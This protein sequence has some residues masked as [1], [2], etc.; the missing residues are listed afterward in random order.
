[1]VTHR[2]AN[3]RQQSSDSAGEALRGALRSEHAE[4]YENLLAVPLQQGWVAP[5]SK[6]SRTSAPTGWQ[7]SPSAWFD[8]LR[9][10]MTLA[11]VSHLSDSSPGFWKEYRY[12][13]SIC[14]TGL[15]PKEFWSPDGLPIATYRCSTDYPAHRRAMACT[16]LL[17]CDEHPWDNG[18]L[19][20]GVLI[21]SALALEIEARLHAEALLAWLLECEHYL[22]TPT[23]RLA[24]LILRSFTTPD[25]PRLLAM[26][27]D[28]LDEGGI[29]DVSDHLDPQWS[30]QSPWND[31][32]MQSISISARS[33]G[34]ARVLDELVA[35]WPLP[36]GL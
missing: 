19:S 21:Q 11:D 16:L 27:D 36:R 12:I 30:D 7:A 20:I 2:M 33:P 23:L 4:D 18:F 28:F 31:L 24:L 8:W 5:E 35:A 26:A 14:A 22:S 15:L 10:R 6:L 13:A 25:D 9:R 29:A 17:L 1:M 32:V 34:L 3:V